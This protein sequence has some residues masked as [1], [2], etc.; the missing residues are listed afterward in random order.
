VRL[1]PRYY[2]DVLRK[3]VR[4]VVAEVRGWRA[5]GLAHDTE[6]ERLETICRQL[7]AREEQWT[8]D[9]SRAPRLTRVLPLGSLLFAVACGLIVRFGYA[10]DSPV[11]WILP[12]CGTVGL[13]VAGVLA[14]ARNERPLAAPLLTGGL[15]A[16]LP[17]LIGL[18]QGIG[19]LTASAVFVPGLSWLQF[20][21]A[22]GAVFLCSMGLLAW[23]REAIY[24]L[25]TCLAFVA[26]FIGAA[27]IFGFLG[28]GAVALFPLAT[29]LLAARQFEVHERYDWARPFF[30][31]GL[32][33]LVGVPLFVAVAAGEPL[34]AAGAGAGFL[35]AAG[36]FRRSGSTSIK[37]TGRW[38][39]A[40]APGIVVAGLCV[41][42][43]LSLAPIDWVFALAASMVL[44][45]HGAVLRHGSTF[46]WGLA[47]LLCAAAMP[48]LFGMATPWIHASILGGLGLLAT[49]AIAFG[50]LRSREP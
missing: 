18:F 13:L 26:A 40:S 47:G 22:S 8:H 35:L 12:L 23:R 25:A 48:A 28:V 6:A 2:R 43:G 33:A 15:L 27:G 16:M 10:Y 9:P 50:S 17:A 24:A 38:L 31:A 11:A 7:L 29:L 42:A 41:H 3:R 49:G 37:T 32:T 20:A 21:I 5:Q 34:W 46:G 4:E 45:A 36:F 44:I 30:W 1:R 19:L 39:D 14:A